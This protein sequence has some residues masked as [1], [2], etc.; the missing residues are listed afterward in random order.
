MIRDKLIEHVFSPRIRERLLLE[1]DLTLDR[2]VKITSQIE[3]AA[4]PVQNPLLIPVSLLLL[5]KWCN[6]QSA[7]CEKN[8]QMHLLIL[9]REERRNAFTVVLHLEFCAFT[10][11]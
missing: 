8:L 2:A 7:E 9:H 3:S 5:F 4:N 10:F 6:M 1:T 11:C